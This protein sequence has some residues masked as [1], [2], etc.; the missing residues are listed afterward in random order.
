MSERNIVAILHRKN[1]QVWRRNYARLDTAIRRVTQLAV[2]EG[3]P[4]D[5]VEIAHAVTGLQIG[6]MK[7]G[8]NSLRAS[9]V[10]DA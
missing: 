1:G 3:E 5:V 10:W 8:V 2:T 9:W 6:T 4:K 7:V